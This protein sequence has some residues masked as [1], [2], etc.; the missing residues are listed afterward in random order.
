MIDFFRKECNSIE[1]TALKTNTNTIFINK[2]CC[3]QTF[4]LK[5]YVYDMIDVFSFPTEQV[6]MID[7]KYDIRKC[8][9]YLNL[10][11][12][13]SCLCFSQFHLQSKTACQG[14]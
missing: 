4:L 2:K 8:Y 3:F 14:I 13:E 11:D 9:M 12:R 7:D 6:K 5:C 10:T 1:S